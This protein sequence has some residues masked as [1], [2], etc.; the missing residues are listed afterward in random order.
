[1]GVGLGTGCARAVVLAGLLIAGAIGQA[2]PVCAD[3]TLP[4]PPP[5][6]LGVGPREIWVGVDAGATNWLVYSGGTYAPW[7][8][9]HADGFRLR[10]TDGY[11]QYTSR[12]SNIRATKTYADVLAGYQMRFGELTAKAFL[13][14][15]FLSQD[16]RV[17]SSA[18][19]LRDVE[20]GVKGALE[21][22]LNIGKDGW[23][24]LDASYADT[25]AT[26]SVRSRLGYRVL[27]T[28][29]VGPEAI[30]NHS[31]EPGDV[32]KAAQSAA[33]SGDPSLAGASFKGNARVGG[34]VRY[35][36]FGG[37]ISASG[38]YSGDW[39]ERTTGSTEVLHDPQVYGTLNLI[40]QF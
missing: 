25:R 1:M 36:W 16:F 34:F 35:E 17:L 18:G 30:F 8:D 26:W 32:V 22:W 38:G 19:R 31:D 15:A 21:L 2:F 7:S 39:I 9:I 33:P 40:V 14:Y 10:A 3:G 20:T 29:S 27:P 23:A 5:P 28:V 13:G 4:P 37:E 12:V 24:S 11:G 6:P